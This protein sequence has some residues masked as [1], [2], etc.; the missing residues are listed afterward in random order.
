[1]LFLSSNIDGWLGDT[2]TPPNIEL[3]TA[4]FFSLNFLAA[5]QDIAVDGWALTMLKRY[6]EIREL[7]FFLIIDFVNKFFRCNVGHASTCNSVGQT[8]GYFLGYVLF[9]ALE[10]ASFC[11]GYLRSTP[12]EEGL[13]TLPGFLYF[14]GCVFIITT[15]LIAIFKHEESVEPRKGEPDMD[16]THAYKLLWHITRLPTIKTLAIILLTAKVGV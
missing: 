15:T 12:S 9:I 13:V 5:T 4:L 16:I 11:N 6:V 8:A 14:W 10:S 2:H 1:M 7:L 3:L